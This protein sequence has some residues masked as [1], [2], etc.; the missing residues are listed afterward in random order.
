MEPHDPSVELL[1]EPM[2]CTECGHAMTKTVGDYHYVESGLDNVMLQNVPQ[3]SCPNCGAKRVTIGAVG[4]L[5]RA[6]AK[7]L[8]EK[9]ARLLPPEVAFLRDHLDLSNKEFAEVMGVSPEQAS[10][11]SSS[12]PIGVPAE[13]LLRLLATLGPEGVAGR[14]IRKD[15]YYERL[16]AEKALAKKGARLVSK[17]ERATSVSD[18]VEIVEHFPPRDADAKDVKIRIKRSGSEGWKSDDR[19]VN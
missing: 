18:L 17:S 8:A 7:S 4:A 3:H 15:G 16:L 2:K 13:R 10:R 14:K 11:W 6:I 19:S 1:E 12:E 9:P 5:H